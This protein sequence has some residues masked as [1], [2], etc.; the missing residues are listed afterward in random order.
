MKT[1]DKQ[2]AYYL[3]AKAFERDTYLEGN[4][5]SIE[6]Q[7][8]CVDDSG[9]IT[10]PDSMYDG[11]ADLEF[12]CRWE[13]KSGAINTYGYSVSYR[14]L[15]RIELQDLG[16]LTKMLK[17]CEKV[18]SA[19]PVRPSGFGQWLQMMAIGLHITKIVELQRQRGTMYSESEHRT[20]KQNEIQVLME[21]RIMDLI[22]E[23][24]TAS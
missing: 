18:E 15:Y 3:G 20:W 10:N 11:F 21:R 6:L 5:G 1:T 7:I 9:K 17:R 13:E 24:V 14:N 22:T 8:V 12:T 16:R 23:P 19:F 2:Y 4:K